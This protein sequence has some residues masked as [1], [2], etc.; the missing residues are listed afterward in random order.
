MTCANQL[1]LNPHPHY[2][3]AVNNGKCWN[4][5]KKFPYRASITATCDSSRTIN[6]EKMIKLIFFI[7]FYFYFALSNGFNAIVRSLAS[8][9]VHT[10]W[11]WI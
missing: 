5:E 6:D 11:D 10:F 1:P 2:F 3:Y 7:D 4:D 9:Y 8:L